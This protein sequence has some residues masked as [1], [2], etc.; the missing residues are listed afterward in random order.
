MAAYLTIPSL[1]NRRRIESEESGEGSSITIPLLTRRAVHEQ[2]DH[3]HADTLKLSLDGRDIA[4]VDPQLLRSAV[5]AFHLGNADD[6][7]NWEPAPENI[8]FIGAMSECSRSA[9]ADEPLIVE[10]EFQDYTQ[11]FLRRKP[12][13][14]DGIPSYSMDL[15]EAW[16]LICDHVGWYDPETGAIISSV[17]A[18]RDAI[19]FKIED[20]RIGA[21][22]VKEIPRLSSAVSKRFAKL[23]KVPVHPN[24][25]A[26]AVWLQTVG[27]CGLISYIDGD[28]CVV[29]TSTNLYTSRDMPRL[30]WGKNIHTFTERR[31]EAIANKGIGLTSF[32]PLSGTTYE[33]FWP[34]I[35]SDELKRK[36]VK[37]TKK[38]PVTEDRLRQAEDRTYFA[39]PGIT[40]LEQL[41]LAAKRVYDER[42][43]QELEGSAST[44]DMFTETVGGSQ[45]D[46]LELRAGDDIRVEFEQRD[47]EMISAMDSQADR[48]EYLEKRGYSPEVAALLAESGDDATLRDPTFYVRRVTT[49]LD[50]VGMSFE[51]QVDFVNK[52]SVTGDASS[53]E[54]QPGV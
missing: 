38:R 30:I 53:I 48:I 46:L 8:R 7:G 49:T 50:Y 10:A 51:V 11:F 23:G 44:V 43:R 36:Q 54:G 34:P 15:L 32:D 28:R 24:T 35:G 39:V 31:K 45:F 52:I 5:V 40:N 29:T 21:G 9:K 1:G 16:Q 4:G 13:P 12:F 41:T 47:R 3:M 33:A 14:T 19:D 25:D 42:S 22:F 18:L 6:L 2:N 37:A 17:S 27:M 26:W 20:P